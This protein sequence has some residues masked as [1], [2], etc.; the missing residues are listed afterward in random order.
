MGVPRACAV[1]G[2][3]A[4]AELLAAVHARG[5]TA[6]GAPHAAVSSALPPAAT[7]AAPAPRKRRRAAIADLIGRLDDP[8]TRDARRMGT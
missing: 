3:V 2:S 6:A 5:S 7:V 4:Y 8:H 1:L